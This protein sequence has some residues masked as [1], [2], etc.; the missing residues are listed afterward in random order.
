MNSI[1]RE[2]LLSSGWYEGRNVSIDEYLEWYR[3]EGYKP[4][5]CVISFLKEFGGLE[6]TI[7]TKLRNGSMSDT[8]LICNPIENGY[9]YEF[10]DSYEKFFGVNMFPVA[11]STG[12]PEL[13]ID[14]NGACY[15]MYGSI[16]AKWGDSFED[17]ILNIMNG[18][19]KNLEPIY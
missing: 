17:F 11:T 16:G 8:I 19:V 14:S 13:F 1:V 3:S 12:P 18:N 7:P 10:I 15:A 9:E 4:S 2:I 5:L 6:I